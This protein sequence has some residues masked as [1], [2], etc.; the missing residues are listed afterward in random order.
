MAMTVL[1]TLTTAGIDTG[2][3]NLYSDV[4]GYLAA[5][6]SGVTRTSLLAGYSSGKIRIIKDKEF[7]EE[8]FAHQ[9]GITSLY[10]DSN[11]ERIISGRSCAHLI[12]HGNSPAPKT[13]G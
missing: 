4:D 3:F 12:N 11:Y 9:S 1:I 5:F 6:E 10:Y 8:F 2:P 7:S 13:S